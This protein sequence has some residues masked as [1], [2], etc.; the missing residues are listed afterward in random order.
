MLR[1]IDNVT[2]VILTSQTPELRAHWYGQWRTHSYRRVF[3]YRNRARLSSWLD[4]PGTPRWV[5]KV[6][7][8]AYVALDALVT[9]FGIARIAWLVRRNGLELI[10]LAN[11]MEPVEAL[12]AGNLIDVPVIAHLRGY[13]QNS[14]SLLFRFAA[15]P[16]LVIG[17]S[18][19]VSDSFRENFPRSVPV[20]TIHEVVDLSEFE[21]SA[22]MAQAA[23]QRLGVVEDSVVVGIFGRVIPWKGQQEF[24]L[25]VTEAMVRNPNIVGVIVGDPADGT[26]DYFDEVKQTIRDSE[27]DGRFRLPGYVPDVEPLYHGMDIIVHASVEP[28][29]C[30]MV[31]LEGMAAARP[32]IASADGGPRELIRHGIDGLL[33]PP[34]DVDAMARAIVRLAADRDLRRRMGE[35]GQA[36][37]RSRFDVPIAAAKLRAV[38]DRMVTPV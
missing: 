16:V 2:P 33:V 23:R 10:H 20:D 14:S 35:S 8:R 37:V 5:R 26:R 30:G 27:M 1:E 17:D 3:N 21:R 32:V 22:K 12:I 11:G 28:E 24:V 25:A 7:T 18:E 9:L 38:Y 29:P 31:V 4:R 6:I 15:T 19:S 36:R 34:G 13:Y